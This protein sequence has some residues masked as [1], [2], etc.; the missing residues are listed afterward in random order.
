MAKVVF[1]AAL[2]A[3]L[4]AV[5]VAQAQLGESER[6]MRFR[7]MQCLQ[8]VQESSLDAC[9]QVLDRQLTGRERFHPMFRQGAMGQR[10]QCCQQLQDVSRQCRCS[11]IRRMVRD[12]EQSMP[13]MEEGYYGEGSEEEE[14]GQG[15]YG[16]ESSSQQQQEQQEQGYYGERS[17][18][19]QQQQRGGERSG[20]GC[21]HH[22]AEHGEQQQQ[23]QQRGGERSGCGCSHHAAEHGEQQPRMTRV[24]LIRA[25]QYAAQLPA[26]CRIEPQQCSIFAAGQN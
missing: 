2:L 6:M 24:R 21:S 4:V 10:L 1:F 19:Q 15:Y 14:Q 8:E 12:Y 7:D 23:Q 16:E 3:A 5:S 22:A 13:S 18:E 17:W 26:M 25:K 9:R 20:C 11:A